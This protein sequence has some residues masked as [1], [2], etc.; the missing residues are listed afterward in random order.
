[1]VVNNYDRSWQIHIEDP[2]ATGV[3]ITRRD[4][5]QCNG[6]LVEVDEEIL[7]EYDERE[8]THAYTKEQIPHDDIKT[9]NGKSIEGKI[10]GYFIDQHLPPSPE[11]PILQSYV[12]VILQ[13]CLEIDFEFARQFIHDTKHWQYLVNDRKAPLY[14]RACTDCNF[15]EIDQLL[16]D[17]LPEVI[18][19]R[20]DTKNHSD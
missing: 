19:D 8:L 3:G 13:G 5:F 18:E 9:L 12:D 15:D 7:K 16:K 14:P 2:R 20:D 17:E 1:M 6:V 4:N 10:F 11:Y